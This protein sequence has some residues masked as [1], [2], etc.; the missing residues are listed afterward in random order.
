MC[1]S[2]RFEKFFHHLHGIMSKSRILPPVS[3]PRAAYAAMATCEDTR[4]C[5]ENVKNPVIGNDPLCYE[6]ES[7]QWNMQSKRS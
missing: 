7:F 3:L 5:C 4:E 6:K 2:A 1:K